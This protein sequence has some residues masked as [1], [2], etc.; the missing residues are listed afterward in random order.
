MQNIREILRLIQEGNLSNRQIAKSCHCSPTTIEAIIARYQENQLTWPEVLK[1]DDSELESK[2]YPQEISSS[3]KPLPDYDYIHQELMRNKGVT[4]LLLWQEYKETY[5]EGVQYTQF[6]DHYLTWR[7]LRDI[8]M[9]QIHRAGEKL[10]TDWAGLT[11]SVI[12]RET[13][14]VQPAYFFVAVLGACKLFYTEPFLAMDLFPWTQGHIH[15]FEYFGGVTEIIVPDNT[16]TAVKKPCY[17]EPEINP[18]YLEMASHYGAVVIPARVRKPKD[19]SPVEKEVQDVERWIIA[20]LRNQTFFS[21]YELKQAVRLLLDEANNRPFQK[22]E[23]SRRSLFK[24]IEKSA[25]KPLPMEAYEFAIWSRARVNVDYHIEFDK[26]YYSVPYQLVKQEV[27]VRAAAMTVEILH[28]NKRVAAHV[29]VNGKKHVYTT[30]MEHMP[31]RHRQFG[32]WTPERIANWSRTVGPHTT[33]LVQAIMDRKLHPEQ[34]FRACMGIIRLAKSYSK[35]RVENASK[36]AL[37]YG[38]IS[39][40]SVFSILQKNLDLN[41]LPEQIHSE[42]LFHENLRGSKYYTGEAH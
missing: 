19:K 8:S 41:P 36:R 6:C 31:P 5:P 38:A 37:T 30:L 14:E 23:G 32:E 13:G 21:L 10:F 11:G 16:K 1:M 27:M 7:K 33:G 9:H 40:Q 17:Y 22:R 34:A 39:Y 29:R 26:N 20:K 12:D 42:P 3:K 35:E 15:A 2:L 28:K 4:L 25:L 24:T 18:T